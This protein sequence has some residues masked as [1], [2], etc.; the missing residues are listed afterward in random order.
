MG[1]KTAR[2][3][4]GHHNRIAGSFGTA[5]VEEV[6]AIALGTEVSG[7]EVQALFIVQKHVVAHTLYQRF[8]QIEKVLA[9]TRTEVRDG[10]RRVED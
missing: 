4:V 3:V 1:A 5:D 8:R 10:M 9:A 7:C 2:A 6:V